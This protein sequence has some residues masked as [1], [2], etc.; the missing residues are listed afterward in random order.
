[1]HEVNFTVERRM[2]NDTEFRRF[3]LIIIG[4]WDITKQYFLF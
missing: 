2:S 4:H 1:M 3:I